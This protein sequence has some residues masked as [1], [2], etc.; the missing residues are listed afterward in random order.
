MDGNMMIELSFGLVAY[1]MPS[2]SFN[3][4]EKSMFDVILKEDGAGW[5][6]MR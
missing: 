4:V 6:F 5:W 3:Q 1:G 2:D